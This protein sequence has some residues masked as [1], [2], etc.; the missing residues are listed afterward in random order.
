[1]LGYDRLSR[2]FVARL[3]RSMWIWIN[4]ATSPYLLVLTTDP[5]A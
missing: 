2:D 3:S 5:I 1:M 4:N